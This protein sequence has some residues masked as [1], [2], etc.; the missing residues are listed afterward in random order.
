MLRPLLFL[1]VLTGGVTADL[2]SKAA[3]FES[4]P[5]HTTHVV[6]EGL[7][8]IEPTRNPGAMWSLF[9]E[10]PAWIW[11]LIR[12]SIALGLL[13]YF[14]RHRGEMGLWVQLAFAGVLA[15]AVG[16]LHDNAFAEGGMVRD[17]IVMWIGSY[18]WPTYN[19]ADSLICV[20]AILLLIYFFRLEEPEKVR[21]KV[22]AVD[23]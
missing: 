5:E 11:I 16:N 7:L 15:G 23:A 3:A 1:L 4:V 10:V 14:L 13:L 6:S 19:V 21:S 20:G 2:W 22:K 18:K 12:G 17:F 8:A 9:Q